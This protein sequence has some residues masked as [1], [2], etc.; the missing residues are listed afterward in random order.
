[1]ENREDHFLQGFFHPKSIAV[2]GASR[3]PF[4]ANYHLIAN[5]VKLGFPGK[6]YPINPE[7]GEIL[8]LEVY[9]NIKAIE[10]PIDLAIVA[11]SY[12]STPRLLHECIEKGIKKVVVVAGGFSETGEEGRRVQREMAG[13]LKD[14]G[15]RAIGP[16]ALSPI[17]TSINLAIS[18]HPIDKMKVGGLSLIF[19]SGLYEPR[20]DWL[21]SDFNLQLNKLI[22]LGNKMDIN[23]VDALTY[24]IRDPQ[25]KVIGIHLES[26][27]G[28]GREFLRL[29]REASRDKHVVVLKSG[30]TE[31][32]AQAAASHTGV[33]VQ[34]SDLVFD[35][36]LKQSGALRAQNIEEFFDLTRA[37]ECFGS[38]L[39]PGNRIA[40]ATLPGGEAVIVTDLCQFAGLSL[41]KIANETLNQLRPIFPPWEIS[42]NPF[43]LGVSLQFNDIRRVYSILLESMV[44][45]PNVDGFAVQFPW[46][47]IALPREFFQIFPQTLKAKK[48]IAVW[49]AGMEPGRNEILEWLNDQ[50]VPVFPSPEKVIKALS[51]LHRSTIFK[52]GAVASFSSQLPPGAEREERIS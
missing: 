43:D 31:A 13:L 21:F 49:V 30:R 9:P 3:N 25:T 7:A 5:L 51:A 20:L 45:D 24:L 41:A 2:V 40:M 8:G 10:D 27:E 33:I 46:R 26:I 28:D 15:V 17:N 4:R 6:I 47:A 23:E 32:G 14:S 18:F 11:V 29:I 39:L 37:L 12:Q 36:A 22:D 38:L 48:P 42:G 34:G 16:N 35:A 50:N 44:H 19:Q 1:M 52:L